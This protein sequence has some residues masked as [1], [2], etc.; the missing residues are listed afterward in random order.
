MSGK[1]NQE[2]IE[3]I[4][5]KINQLKVK[6]TQI[7]NRERERKKKART[8]RLIQIGIIF[9]KHFGI[10]DEVEAEKMAWAFK[11]TINK[12]RFRIK[13]IDLIRSRERNE[14]VYTTIETNRGG[15]HS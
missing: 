3:E 4:E 10:T 15:E 6:K 7:E 1:T 13:D 12:D 5:Q 9:E 8:K 11:Q 14:A 2:R